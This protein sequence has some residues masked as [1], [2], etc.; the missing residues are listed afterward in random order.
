M[1][2]NDIGASAPDMHTLVRLGLKPVRFCVTAPPRLKSGVSDKG[3]LQI[4]RDAY[5]VSLPVISRF[6]DKF[7]N[8]IQANEKTTSY[9]SS[10]VNVPH[11][12]LFLQ[13]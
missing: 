6:G 2:F 4:N 3:Y 9:V 8:F 5:L 1:E 13:S 7:P 10:S 12:I 11:A